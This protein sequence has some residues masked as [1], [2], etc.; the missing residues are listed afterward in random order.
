MAAF[1]H[2]LALGADGLELDV[3]L[4]SDGVARRH[5]RS[6]RS[7]GPRRARPVW[8]T[9][10]ELAPRGRRLP[11]Q[12]DA[13]FP[14]RGRGI[15]VP[16]W[17]RSLARYP[18]PRHH[19]DEG[20][21]PTLAR[22]VLD[23]LRR[24]DAV[25]RVCLGSFG[26]RVLERRARSSPAWPRARRER[27]CGGRCTDRGVRWPVSRVAVSRVSGAASSPGRTRGGLAAVRRR[28]PSRRARRAGLDGR[29]T[30]DEARRLLGWGVDGADHGSAGSDGRRSVID[31]ART[32]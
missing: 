22:A 27:K 30:E 25:E 9:R 19:R 32:P 15:G 18:T 24:A 26:R 4:S 12:V 10:S 1:D 13:A 7:I 8:P 3:H 6:R 21:A 11:V 2:G 31:G 16:R 20:I 5:P 23:V 14:F 17:S 29:T 28:G